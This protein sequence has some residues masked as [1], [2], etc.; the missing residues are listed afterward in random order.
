[1][2]EIYIPY[3]TATGLE[4]HL[5]VDPEETHINLDLRDV[6]LVDLLPLAW[7]SKLEELNIRNNQLI[8]IDLSPLEKCSSLRALRLNNNLLENIDL[9]PLDNCSNLIEL[10][11]HR[12]K[13]TRLDISPLVQCHNLADLTL[14]DTTSLLADLTLKSV[15]SWPEVLVERFHRILWKLPE[16][17]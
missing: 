7:C 10:A 9:T 5:K 12:K 3:K 1:M 4:K 11:L 2:A 8:E 15:G 14:D 17:V 13:I 16:D 6:A